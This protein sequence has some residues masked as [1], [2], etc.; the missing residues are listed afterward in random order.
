MTWR[1]FTLWWLVCGVFV[2]HAEAELLTLG[3][4]AGASLIGSGIS[5]LMSWK[6][7][8][9]GAEEASRVEGLN[10]K[11]RKED[12]AREKTRR[13]QDMAYRGKKDRYANAQNF[14]NG[15]TMQMNS[16]A[17]FKNNLNN[18]WRGRR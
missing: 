6:G 12:I 2:S 5:A 8:Q 10:I 3:I 9:K 4:M 11:M 13:A 7:M 15:L 1:F 16:N 17:Q 14:L 18:I